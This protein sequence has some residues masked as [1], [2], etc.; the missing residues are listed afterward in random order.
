MAILSFS[1]SP[2]FG[3]AVSFGIEEERLLDQLLDLLRAR[4]AGGEI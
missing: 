4:L 1:S 2:Q 3:A